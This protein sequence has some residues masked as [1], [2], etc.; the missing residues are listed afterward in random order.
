MHPCLSQSLIILQ[1]EEIT[2]WF[3]KTQNS[4]LKYKQF[5]KRFESVT[6]SR[7]YQEITSFLRFDK[8]FVLLYNILDNRS[9]CEAGL[10][11]IGYFKTDETAMNAEYNFIFI[12]RVSSCQYAL[13][14]NHYWVTRAGD[15]ENHL[16]RC[17]LRVC[18]YFEMV[19]LISII[20]LAL[21][22]VD[23]KTVSKILTERVRDGFKFKGMI[24]WSAENDLST[25]N[26]SMQ[27]ST[28]SC[29]GYILIIAINL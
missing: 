3:K 27:N 17:S 6:R 2:P 5:V 16:I 24:C 7:L 15:Q 10:D 26:T 20:D 9:K 1:A 19:I 8:L 25:L 11:Y 4:N 23:E 22:S 29:F 28:S 21:D 18:V 12:E 14:L 13:E